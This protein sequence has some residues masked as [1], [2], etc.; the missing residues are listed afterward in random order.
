TIVEGTNNNNDLGAAA[1]TVNIEAVPMPD[2]V[3]SSITPP[4]NGSLSGHTVPVSYVIMNQGPGGTSVPVWSD[5]VI[6]SQD[7]TLGQTYSGQFNATGPGGDQALNNQPVIVSAPN[8][9]YLG[10]GQSYRQTVNVPLPLS[11][12]GTWYVYVVPDGTGAH[13]P[14]AMPEVSR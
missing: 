14:F 4:P 1:G 5:W 3:V 9:T 12:Q 11:A 8:L 6:L 10:P 13:H 2:L 7:P